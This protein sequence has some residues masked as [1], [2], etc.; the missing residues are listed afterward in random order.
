MSQRAVQI[1]GSRIDRVTLAQARDRILALAE[2]GRGR[3]PG[4]R[5]T[6]W[7][8]TANPEILM[9]A[10]RDPLLARVLAEAVL[11]VPDGIG[12]L[13]A[14]RLKGQSLPERVPGIELLEA[15]LAGAAERGLRPFLLGARP[16]II[17][18]AARRVQERYPALSLAGWR[19]G[20]FNLDDP[21]PVEAVATS[22]ADLLFV[23]MGAERELKWLYANR[24]QLG[25]PVAMGVGGSFDVLSG[26]IPR[27]PRWMRNLHLEWFYRL[28]REP[29]RWRRQSVLPLFVASV[30]AERLRRG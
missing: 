13:L 30:V 21:A 20:Y 11:V 19:D 12:V 24:R 5:V 3:P 26:A 6:R 18:A 10:R 16:A 28:L 4:Q 2:T 1:L 9:A 29:R 22:G 15:L 7:V 23:G 17:A 14:A 25:V 27:A 8:V